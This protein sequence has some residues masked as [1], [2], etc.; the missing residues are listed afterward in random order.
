MNETQ[1]RQKLK[2]VLKRIALLTALAFLLGT[3]IGFAAARAVYAQ[4][5]STEAVTTQSAQVEQTEKP[6]PVIASGGNVLKTDLY[7]TMV[8][9]CSKYG[10]PL[11]L[12]IAVAE[13]ES[14]FNPDAVSKTNDYGIMQINKI[15]H[16]W[17]RSRGVEPMSHKGNIEAGA[18]ML[19]DVIKK[20]GDYNKALM[21]YNC[22]EGGAQKLWKKGVYSTQYSR[23]VMERYNKWNSYLGGV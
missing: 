3:A 13:Q 10:V 11:A 12:L 1:R 14:N 22:G 17:L 16:G 15:N 5:A 21:A 20:Y 19:G 23:Q 2:R 4:S 8:E 6:A 7:D 9:M 18:L